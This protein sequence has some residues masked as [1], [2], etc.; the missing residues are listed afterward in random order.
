MDRDVRPWASAMSV[1]QRE[2]TAPELAVPTF[3]CRCGPAVGTPVPQ[4][5]YWKCS[6]PTS[7]KPTILQGLHPGL[8]RAPQVTEAGQGAA[9]GR[10]SSSLV[11]S[12]ARPPSAEGEER[13]SHRE[14]RKTPETGKGGREGG[15][16]D[17]SVFIGRFIDV[18]KV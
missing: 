10:H 3:M 9:G 8:R 2:W 4:G 6:L 1:H 11:S 12:T 15:N 14:E 17:S 18:T 7:P 16:M 5:T 13:W